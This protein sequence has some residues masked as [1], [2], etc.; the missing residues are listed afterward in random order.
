MTERQARTGGKVYFI[1]AGPGA[2]DLITLRGR[3]LIDNADCII[4]AGSLVN[5]ELFV[6]CRV[7]LHDSAGLHLD[8]IIGLMAAVVEQGG[9]VA[10]VHTGDPSLYGAIKEQMVR[11]EQRG[12]AWEVVP[13]VSS[14][15]AAA[16]ALGAEL[17]QPEVTQSVIITRR[18]GRT[19]VPDREHLSRLAA[20]G[21][22][23]MIFL[24]VGMI[25]DVVADLLAGGYSPQ[26]PVAVVMKASWP[27]QR[28]VTGTLA[29]IGGAVRRAGITKT[30]MICVGEVFGSSQ[31][32]AQSR[33]YDQ[34][35][36]HACRT[37]GGA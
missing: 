3:R 19:P 8:E 23:M 36:S 18:E 13:G 11:L 27:D 17:T 28:T 14:A 20:S 6:D 16:A 26:T 12:I 2:V 25:E 24:S 29:D 30:A 10:R 1:G 35:F 32:P 33:L 21:A 15:F 7:P 4:Y 31:P 37:Q 9:T 34:S 5:P 22:T